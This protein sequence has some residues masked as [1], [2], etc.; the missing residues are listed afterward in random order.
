MSKQVNRTRYV[1]RLD[2]TELEFLTTVAKD[3]NTTLPVI[4]RLATALLHQNFKN[5]HYK[6]MLYKQYKRVR[7]KEEVNR[8]RDVVEYMT[9]TTYLDKK[10][11]DALNVLADNDLINNQEALEIKK[12]K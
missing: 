9:V 3:L 7:Y 6:D 4:V 10:I 8:N 11:S 2:E 12:K 1:I 5:Q